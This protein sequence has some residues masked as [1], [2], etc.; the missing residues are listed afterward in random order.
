MLACKSDVKITY[1]KIKIKIKKS[2]LRIIVYIFICYNVI[3]LVRML[4]A[5]KNTIVV[6]RIINKQE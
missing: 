2:H 1:I 3:I 5:S 6:N 4:R